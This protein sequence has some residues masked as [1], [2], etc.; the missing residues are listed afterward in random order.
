MHET[1]TV[2]HE[3]MVSTVMLTNP[4]FNLLDVQIMDDLLAAHREADA[5][6][7]TRVIVTR[8][9]L[10]GM[11]C[12]GLNPLLVL[13]SDLKGRLAFFDAV[14]RMVYG[15]YSLRKPHIAVLNGPAMAGGAVLAITADF[16]YM[17]Q[18]RGAFCFA[19]SKVG[20][21]V[22]EGLVAVI[23]EVCS[24]AMLREV[25]LLGKNL[26]P[27]L[28]FAAG[29]VDGLANAHNLDEMVNTQVARLARLSP[30]VLAETKA[31]L[32]AETLAKTARLAE[33]SGEGF[34]QF[35]GDAYLGEGLKAYLE[36]RQPLYTK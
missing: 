12:N 26:K 5:Y 6:L 34:A 22:P 11:F 36:G 29:L 21:P 1:I 2:H 4:P 24:P 17:D 31:A 14:G 32:R 35:L 15:L 18:E 19:E 9:G 16:R 28:A 10:E 7:Q 33:T 30:G 3:G 20:V 23:A 27:E 8:S 13:E 25:V